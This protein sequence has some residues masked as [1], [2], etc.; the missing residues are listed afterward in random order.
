[1]FWKLILNNFLVCS[2]QNLLQFCN[3][4]FT[5]TLTWQHFAFTVHSNVSATMCPGLVRPLVAVVEG[6]L[7]SR[8]LPRSFGM[9]HSMSEFIS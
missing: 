5:R 6:I 1:M 4:C 3:T 8:E 7:V 2:D 9:K